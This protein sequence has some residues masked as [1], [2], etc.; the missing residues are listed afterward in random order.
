M[1]HARI[2]GNNS[3]CIQLILLIFKGLANMTQLC[4]VRMTGDQERNHN[5]RLGI[6]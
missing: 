3:K 4:N 1:K 5:P 2:K 6:G